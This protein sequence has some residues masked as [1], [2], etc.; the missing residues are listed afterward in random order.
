MSKKFL[1]PVG[2]PSGNTLPSVGSAGDLFFK[3]DEEKVYVHN[4]TGW[5]LADTVGSSYFVSETAPTSPAPSAGDIWFNSA[6]GKTFVYYDSFWVE[7]GQNNVGPTGPTG[8]TGPAASTEGLATEDYVDEAIANIYIEGGLAGE[9]GATGPTGPTGP[10]GAEG[11]TG[12]TGAEGGFSST[13]T[14]VNT[15]DPTRTLSQSDVGKL[16]CFN[17]SATITVQGLTIGQQVDFLQTGTGQITF[18][19]GVDGG[20]G[21]PVTLNSKAGELKTA[22]QWSAASIK[23]ISQDVYVLVGDLGA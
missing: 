22:E 1:T 17:G 11:A 19:A 12:P 23:C 20:M 2:L 13:Q 21:F 6:T 10:T 18:Q 15:Q 5:V 9:D 14:T 7:P 4:S 16:F 3:A 8:P